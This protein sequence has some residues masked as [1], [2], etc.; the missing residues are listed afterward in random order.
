MN[1]AFK[2]DNSYHTARQHKQNKKNKFEEVKLIIHDTHT[3]I[4]TIQETNS[5][6]R[7]TLQK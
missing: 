2:L 4:I 6:L 3:D 7:Q 5:P 1:Q